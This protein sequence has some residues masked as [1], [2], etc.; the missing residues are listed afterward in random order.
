MVGL[1]L[2]DL[3]AW[4]PVGIGLR[5][6]GATVM[7]AKASLPLYNSLLAI[8]SPPFWLRVENGIRDRLQLRSF[9]LTV[10]QSIRQMG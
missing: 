3:A 4:C 6:G 10:V 8:N 9:V 5:G 2:I 7:V 1:D